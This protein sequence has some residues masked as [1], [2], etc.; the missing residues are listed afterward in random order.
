MEKTAENYMEVRK[1]LVAELMEI[2]RKAHPGQPAILQDALAFGL[3]L[4]CQDMDCL[5]MMASLIRRYLSPFGKDVL[6]IVE[7]KLSEIGLLLGGPRIYDK[8]ILDIYQKVLLERDPEDRVEAVA[9]QIFRDLFSR[10]PEY[11]REVIQENFMV[12]NMV[13]DIQAGVDI[14]TDEE[15]A[16]SFA[17]KCPNLRAVSEE[18]LKHKDW[19]IDTR[20]KFL[21]DMTSILLCDRHTGQY[22]FS[23]AQ[24]IFKTEALEWI[25]DDEEAAYGGDS[26][27]SED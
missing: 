25:Q 8:E 9:E 27:E 17:V 19:V 12:R 16:W 3:C 1:D 26:S 6:S 13:L 4:S 21:A 11:T 20:K 24:E 10:D 22:D 23:T 18:L 7:H 2:G 5:A 14:M 15:F